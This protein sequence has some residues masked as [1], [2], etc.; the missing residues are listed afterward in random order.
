MYLYIYIEKWGQ[1][2]L[3]RTTLKRI[4]RRAQPYTLVYVYI[5]LETDM[6]VFIHIHREGGGVARITPRRRL[7]TCVTIHPYICVYI[8]IYMYMNVSIHT[9]VYVYI[10]V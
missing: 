4:C 9:V 1:W 3:T 7:S 10:Y 2:G 8:C 6:N 5:Y